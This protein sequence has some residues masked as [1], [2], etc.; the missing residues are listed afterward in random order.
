MDDAAR[1]EVAEFLDR[2]AEQT[3]WNPDLW[4][5]CYALV[6]ANTANELLRYVYDDLIHYSGLFHSHNI[7]GFRVKPNR[8]V[9]EDYRHE[10]RAIATALRSNLS[11]S[12]AKK[13][14]GL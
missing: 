13:L 8:H 3:V 9:L 6:D 5:K 7:L 2:L 12:E 10:F 4:Q 1:N 14:H 11:L